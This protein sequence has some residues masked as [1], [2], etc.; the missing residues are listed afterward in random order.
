MDNEANGLQDSP[1]LSFWPK[2]LKTPQFTTTAPNSLLGPCN[3]EIDTFKP[4]VDLLKN[5]F[6]C[7]PARSWG[8]DLN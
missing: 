6:Q 3:L 1:E 7:T 2:E 4:E 8:C 5:Y